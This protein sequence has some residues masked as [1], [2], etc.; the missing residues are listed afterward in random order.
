MA[1]HKPRLRTSRVLLAATT[2]A[3]TAFAAG[4]PVEGPFGNLKAPD[5]D[6]GQCDPL[7]LKIVDLQEDAPY[8]NLKA[9]DQY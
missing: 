2:L 4:C 8:G 6:A 9:P 3:S 1:K 5:C 7:D